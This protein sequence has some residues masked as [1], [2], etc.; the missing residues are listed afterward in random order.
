[1]ILVNEAVN[2]STLYDNKTA[3]LG[4]H[5]AVQCDKGRYMHSGHRSTVRRPTHIQGGPK[6]G[7]P[8]CFSGVRF[9]DHPVAHCYATAFLA[10]NRKTTVHA[11]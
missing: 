4:V 8:Y 10:V 5:R 7:Y 9:L 2:V 11:V 1:M 3:L 6:S